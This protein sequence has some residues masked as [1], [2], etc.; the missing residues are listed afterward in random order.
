[1]PLPVTGSAS[2][3]LANRMRCINIHIYMYEEEDGYTCGTIYF[4][5][6]DYYNYTNQRGLKLFYCCHYRKKTSYII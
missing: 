1:M 6:T 4:A 3:A 5:H 2:S